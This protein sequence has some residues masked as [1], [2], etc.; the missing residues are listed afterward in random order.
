MGSNS[1]GQLGIGDPSS[2]FKNTPT[3]VEGALQEHTVVRVSCGNFHSL[4]LTNQGM[5]FSWGQGKFGA[6]GN[7]RSDNQ[8]EPFSFASDSNFVDISAGGSHSGFLSKD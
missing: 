1:H 5:A 2:S 3:L 6:L 7:G 4:A 8:H